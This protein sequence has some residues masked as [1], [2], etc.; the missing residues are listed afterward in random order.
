[1]FL[2]YSELQRTN[3]SPSSSNRQQQFRGLGYVDSR[4]NVLSVVVELKGGVVENDDDK[5]ER[6]VRDDRGR[7]KRR[8]K[9]GIS[10]VRFIED[11]TIEIDLVQDVTGLRSRKGDTG[12]V[13]W[14][15]R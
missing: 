15:A 2:V 7:R 6:R 3:S 5:R 10:G 9:N 1:V 4:R 12:S 13:L 11:K 14:Y 8:R